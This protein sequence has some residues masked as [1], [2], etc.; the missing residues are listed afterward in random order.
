[1]S[2]ASKEASQAVGLCPRPVG[3]PLPVPVE[4]GSRQPY[5]ALVV[6][7]VTSRNPLVVAK[8]VVWS[9]LT[10]FSTV[11]DDSCTLRPLLNGYGISLAFFG[12]K[13]L[14]YYIRACES[15]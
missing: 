12:P 4:D 7:L 2:S 6:Q 1:M 9:P 14:A 11:D 13:N 3:L 15:I 10:S 5:I 8:H